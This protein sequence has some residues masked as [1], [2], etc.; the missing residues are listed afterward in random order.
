M[1]GVCPFS[2]P[3]DDLSS[4][5]DSL[6][7][8]IENLKNKKIL[9]TGGTGFIGKWLT[10]SFISL[11][12][13]FDLKSELTIVSRDPVAFTQ[14]YSRISDHSCIS[15]IKAD[16]C[17]EFNHGGQLFDY[18]IHG[19]EDVADRKG[20][21]LDQ[22]IGTARSIEKIVKAA[23]DCG[24]RFL[25]LSSGAT[26]GDSIFSQR[27]W[28]EA[29]PGLISP[30]LKDSAYTN[31]KRFAETLVSATAM[32]NPTFQFSIARLF[33]FVGPHL[34]L[35]KHFAIGNFI[36]DALNDENIK[37]TGDGQAVRSY[38]YA[39]DLCEWLWTILLCG[40]PGGVYNVGGS[41]SITIRELA[42][43]IADRTGIE[44]Q[45]PVRDVSTD[46][47]TRNFYVPN[48]ELARNELGLSEKIDLTT[49]VEKTI[50][51][52]TST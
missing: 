11:N 16:L 47:S 6:N 18:V 10:G 4:I 22:I 41:N 31:G 25:L 17:N 40:N 35:D 7:N 36:R 27:P 2:L 13:E 32:S 39:S 3:D 33:T 44:L 14:Q 1:R 37:L 23:K 50:K 19:A 9:L 28:E 8:R 12:R 34:P 46:Q 52:I 21:P 45:L 51:W 43:L 29:D 38:M 48:T 20:S 26:Y 15:F 42:E 30:N 24:A 49:A 5:C